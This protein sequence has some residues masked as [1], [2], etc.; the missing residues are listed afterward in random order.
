M[1]NSISSQKKARRGPEKNALDQGKRMLDVR[2]VIPG[3]R[4]LGSPLL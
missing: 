4:R 1:K 3:S 2:Q